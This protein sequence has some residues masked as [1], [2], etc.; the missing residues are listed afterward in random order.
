M[1]R[2]ILS[3]ARRSAPWPW[4]IASTTLNQASQKWGRT[5]FSAERNNGVRPYFLHGALLFLAPCLGLLPL[6]FLIERAFPGFH[7][8]LGFV[9]RNAIAFLDLADELVAIPGDHVQ[10]IVRELAPLLLDLALD[11]LPVAL[12]A[13]PIHLCC[14]L[15]VVISLAF[16]SSFS[17]CCSGVPAP[18]ETRFDG[19][20][21]QVGEKRFDVLRPV[22]RRVVVDERVLPHVHHQ[23]RHEAR[24]VSGLVHLDPLIRHCTGRRVLVAHGPSHAAHL[25][26]A[27]E[28]GFP[29]LVAVPA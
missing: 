13:I 24:D 10:L 11:L 9:F 2:R 8:L 26:D 19:A 27:D 4:R 7:L 29:P 21:I 18:R 25:A 14:L 3:A 12:Y 17:S 23:D 20:P 28:I 16:F 22:F 15:Q 5:P 1:R 6:V